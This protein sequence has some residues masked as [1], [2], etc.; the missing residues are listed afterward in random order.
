MPKYTQFFLVNYTVMKFKK[1]K[2]TGK[3]MLPLKSEGSP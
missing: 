3:V 2:D 1:K